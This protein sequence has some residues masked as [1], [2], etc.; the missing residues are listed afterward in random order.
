MP[1][2]VYQWYGCGRK[3]T[4]LGIAAAVRAARGLGQVQV[5]PLDER[6]LSAYGLFT[7]GPDDQM[8]TF[9]DRF[10]AETKKLG[11]RLEQVEYAGGHA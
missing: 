11:I 9:L 5:G 2:V 10:K 4:M 8:R 3:D 1:N 6:L 7:G